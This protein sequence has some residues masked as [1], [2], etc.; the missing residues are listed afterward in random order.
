MLRLRPKNARAPQVR[1]T[2]SGVG[3]ERCSSTREFRS[4]VERMRAVSAS[5]QRSGR[6]ASSPRHAE[7]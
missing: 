6:D 2:S 7:M 1:S 4:R 5:V 3:H